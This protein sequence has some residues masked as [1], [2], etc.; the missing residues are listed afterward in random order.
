MKAKFSMAV[1]AVLCLCLMAVISASASPPAKAP[2]AI[3]KRIVKAAIPTAAVAQSEEQATLNALIEAKVIGTELPVEYV[4]PF[5]RKIG[6]RVKPLD[7]HADGVEHVPIYTRSGHP[8]VSSS[9]GF[10]LRL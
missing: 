8:P 9:I 5:D 4:S 3:D 10:V 7:G 6:E 2:S 1:L